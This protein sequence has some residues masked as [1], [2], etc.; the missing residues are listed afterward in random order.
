MTAA[1][2][3]ALGHCQGGRSDRAAALLEGGLIVVGTLGQGLTWV[4]AAAE[5]WHRRAPFAG[6]SLEPP[7]RWLESQWPRP[8][9]GSAELHGATGR[10]P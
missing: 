4:G 7:R 3:A 9:P 8:R 6:G 10:A 5:N 2:I 1:G